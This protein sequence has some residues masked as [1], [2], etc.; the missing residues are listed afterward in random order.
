M[1]ESLRDLLLKSGIAKS[2]PKA[3]RAQP[4]PPANK[5]RVPPP[6]AVEIGE[7]DLARAY[8]LR[9][10]TEAR[11]RA[12][13]QR[14]AEQLARA[15]KEA[16]RKLQLLLE[17]KA[18]NKA[19]ADEARHFEYHGKIRRVHV[20]ADQFKALNAGEL[21]VVQLAGRYLVVPAAIAREAAAIDA[22]ALALLVDPTAAAADDGVP[23]DLVW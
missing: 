12:R 21:G 1:T 23:D 20:D 8:A 4:R 22:T 16:R 18:L 7:A 13:E 15:K 3:P 17:G 19:E 9:A 14:E 6:S 10:K 5:P 11:D 2:V